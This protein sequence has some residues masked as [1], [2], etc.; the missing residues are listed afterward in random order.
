MSSDAE[1]HTRNRTRGPEREPGKHPGWMRAWVHLRRGSRREEE[2]DENPGTGEW[3]VA[4]ASDDLGFVAQR[5][6]RPGGLIAEATDTII[7]GVPFA[8]FSRF[9][10]ACHSRISILIYQLS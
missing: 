8:T 1:F 7:P 5:H 3:A 6:S 10:E 9:A 2:E 4:T